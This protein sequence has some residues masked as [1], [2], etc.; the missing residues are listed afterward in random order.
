MGIIEQ[1]ENNTVSL[2]KDFV[3]LSRKKKLS[4]GLEYFLKAETLRNSELFNESVRFYLSSLLI[5]SKNFD[6]YMG[7]AMAYKH[8]RKYEKAINILNKA[9][10]IKTDS[11]EL[12]YE[13][14]VLYLLCENPHAALRE[15]KSAILLDKKK[16]EAQIQLA[17]AHE[18]LDDIEM[19]E[20]IYK[21]I[22]EFFP[23]NISAY[24][25]LANLYITKEKF[26]D[27]GLVY[28]QILKINPNFAQAYFGLGVCFEK[29]GKINDS[30]RYF[31]K[32]SEIKPNSINSG[33]VK[34][35]LQKLK[36]MLPQRNESIFSI[37]DKI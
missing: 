37:V 32:F 36:S 34:K 16:P 24:N 28:K 29:L 27:A 3:K 18:V 20:M 14:G 35:H 1:E 2:P 5:E 30:I 31:R 25:N 7:L 10:K 8:I 33:E 11:Y 22:I 26:L 4:V 15:F 12:H 6:C 23:S 13:L 9:R 19:A 17:K 21:R